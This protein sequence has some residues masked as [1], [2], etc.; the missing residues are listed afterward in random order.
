MLEDA[1]SQ[2]N[3]KTVLI[4]M[5][6]FYPYPLKEARE[7]FEKDYLT[8]QLKKHKGNISKTADLLLVWK[9]QLYTVN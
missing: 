7:K 5:K 2:K 8:S 1:L 4:P 3:N 6:M 9:D